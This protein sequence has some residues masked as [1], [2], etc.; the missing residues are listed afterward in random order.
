MHSGD[1]TLLLPAQKL[2]VATVQKVKKIAAKIAS[3]LKV[4]SLAAIDC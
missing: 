4:C 2:Y 1:A 3:A